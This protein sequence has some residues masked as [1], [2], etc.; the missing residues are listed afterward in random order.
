M[1]EFKT[2]LQIFYEQGIQGVILALEEL[3]AVHHAAKSKPDTA[4]LPPPFVETPKEV[5]NG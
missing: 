2:L 5:N 3:F 1:D 4:P